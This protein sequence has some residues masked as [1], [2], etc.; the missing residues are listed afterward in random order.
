[1]S[2][3]IGKMTSTAKTGALL[4]GL[5]VLLD[6]SVPCLAGCNWQSQSDGTYSCDLTYNTMWH[7]SCSDKPAGCWKYWSGYYGYTYYEGD[8]C[9]APDENDCCKDAENLAIGI[10]IGI[11]VAVVVAI[12]SCIACCF[13]CSGC[14]GYQRMHPPQPAT[15]AAVVMT[16]PAGVVAAVPCGG[17]VVTNGAPMQTGVIPVQTTVQV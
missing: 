12:G 4:L 6:C 8:Y 2:A 11:V 5:A 17:A 9:C 14:P 16:Q 1:M 15:P 7:G 10:I 3:Q 13:C